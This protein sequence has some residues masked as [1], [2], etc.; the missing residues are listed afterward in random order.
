VGA[1]G[2]AEGRPAE[3]T[4]FGHPVGLANLSES[5]CGSASPSTGCSPSSVITSIT[6]SPKVLLGHRRRSRAAEDHGD[7][8]RRRVR[9]A[10]VPVHRARWL[11]AARHGTHGVLRRRSGHV[12]SHRTGDRAG[13]GGCRRRADSCRARL[14]CVEGQRVVIAGNPVREGRCP[15]RRWLHPVL[16]RHQPRSLH[17][18]TDHR[19]V[20]DSRRI[21]LRL[22][23]RGSRHGTGSCPVRPR[24]GETWARTAA[25]CQANCHTA[26]LD[27]LPGWLWSSSP[28]SSWPL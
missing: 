4:L 20:A 6:R 1:V 8:D 18:P 28:S 7:W 23:C 21:P 15:L 2:Q 17:R 14:R 3:R 22:R 11:S 24:S 9:R 26:L 19:P 16:S 5:S 25:L 10:G 12:R 13:F 27:G